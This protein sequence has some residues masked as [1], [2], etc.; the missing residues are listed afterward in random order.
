MPRQKKVVFP[1]YYAPGK[2]LVHIMAKMRDEPGSLASVLKGLA[3]VVNLLGT[4]SYGIGR[5]KA[6]FSGFAETLFN[7]D[8]ADSI[9]ATL[10][11]IPGVLDYQVWE[12]N[13]GFLVDWFHTGLETGNGESYIMFPT[14][15][16]SDTFEQ[17]IEALGPA[18]DTLLF[19]EGKRFGEA[20]FSEYRK[21]LGPNPGSRVEEASHIFHALGYGTSKITTEDS[22]KTVRMIREDCFE[23]SSPTKR[24]R[25]CAFTRGMVAGTFGALMGKELTATETKCRLKGA[26]VCEFVLQRKQ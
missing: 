3:P 20:R 18:G 10:D 2:K 9:R 21:M 22:E 25:T 16:L 17:V 7:T 24:G 19:L 14:K 26:K 5:G 8:S 23:C 12:S 11:E 13:N 1:Y 6:M 15:G 4:S